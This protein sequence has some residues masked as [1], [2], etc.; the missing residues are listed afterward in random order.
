VR[1]RGDDVGGCGMK[2]T[3]SLQTL[4]LVASFA[5]VAAMVMGLL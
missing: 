1:S 4:M 3:E 2:M 5:F